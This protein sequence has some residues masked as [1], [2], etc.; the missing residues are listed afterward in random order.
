ML[1]QFLKV[2][3]NGGFRNSGLS[4]FRAHVVGPNRRREST[5][6]D[7]VAAAAAVGCMTS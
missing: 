3:Y 1:Q 6:Y 2:T 4:A 7:N 5:N